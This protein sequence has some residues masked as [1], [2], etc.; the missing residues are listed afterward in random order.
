MAW[1]IAPRPHARSRI[2]AGLARRPFPAVLL[3]GPTGI[4]KTTLARSVTTDIEGPVAEILGL[5]ELRDVPLGA[6]APAL[7]SATL[8]VDLAERLANAVGALAASEPAVVL[9][10]DAPLL[11]DLS[12][13]AVYQLVRVYKVPCILTA[14]DE[15]PLVGPIQRLEH[16]GLLERIEVEPLTA[17]EV[18]SLLDERFG[19]RVEPESIR[20][21]LS[22]SEGNPLVL[23]TLAVAAEEQH[24][25]HASPHGVVVDEPR[26]P[27]H[28]GAIVSDRLVAL[29]P[30]DR[31]RALVLALAQPVPASMLDATFDGLVRAGLATTSGAL[32]EE[33]VT[34]T[35]PLVTQVLVNEAGPAARRE[36]ATRAAELLS[37][38]ADD[39]LTFRGT[40]LRLRHGDAV[41][42]DELA[43]AATYAHT[44]QDHALA[45]RLGELSAAVSPRHDGELARGSALSAMGDSRAEEALRSA[46]DLA[47]TDGEVALAVVRLGHHLAIR[48]HR[49]ADAVEL[50]KERMPT[51]SDPAALAMVGADLMKWQSMAGSALPTAT[52]PRGDGDGGPGDLAALI[53]E[54]MV[55][56]MLGRTDLTSAAIEAARPLVVAHRAAFPFGSDLIDLNEFLVH[57]FSGQLTEAERFARERHSRARTDAT[58]LWSYALG[59]IALHTGRATEAHTLSHEAVRELAWRDFTGLQ[60]AAIALRATAEAELGLETDPGMELSPAHLQDIKVRL[61]LAEARA[62]RS[63]LAGDVDAATSELV[64][65]ATEGVAANHLALAAL[66]AAT[67]CRFGHGAEV[68]DLLESLA[69]TSGSPLVSAL[70]TSARAQRE[71]T[72]A[73][74]QSAAEQL[75]VVGLSTPA[76]EAWELAARASSGEAARR[77]RREAGR[78]V[79][80]LEVVTLLR[81]EGELT[82]LTPRELAV[83]RAASQRMRSHEIASSLGLSIRTVDNHL[84]RAYRKLGVRNRLELA[85]ALDELAE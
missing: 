26:L 48:A 59:L 54:A 30:G 82:E 25:I 14:R 37:R 55:T 43:W 42:A 58:G 53:G 15:H 41:A 17:T 1:P 21:M 3:T 73:A 12:A 34:I 76:A 35:H 65:A 8:G 16:E 74:L 11:D 47:A 29:D 61:Q 36:A 51:L 80:G 79:D 18:Q 5:E 60:G 19:A 45:I 27:R 84:G 32:G 9:V 85:A 4:G 50:A 2:E 7:A 13:A 38:S 23:R 52:Q 6:L 39:Q 77:A 67:A 49:P 75:D 40:L 24:T 83:A 68:V 78:C 63:A 46:L 72:A 44:V 33:R 66:T 57:V 64:A 56:S 62:W 20:G 28:V 69:T 10:D 31:D 22:R 71:G 81:P 70:A